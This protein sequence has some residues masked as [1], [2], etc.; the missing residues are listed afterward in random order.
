MCYQTH[1][2]SLSLLIPGVFPHLHGLCPSPQLLMPSQ[3]TPHNGMLLIPR[4]RPK[5]DFL[6][7]AGSI[8]SE[9]TSPTSL[10]SH[11]WTLHPICAHSSGLQ[12][13]EKLSLHNPERPMRVVHVSLH[14][15]NSQ[16]NIAQRQSLITVGRICSPIMLAIKININVRPN[17]PN[18]MQEALW[19]HF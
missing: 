12:A 7:E 16:P 6:P 11:G 4:A 10:R 1:P 2:S 18:S 8:R 3:P 19:I 14:S 15:L 5:S 17:S 13:A 9:L